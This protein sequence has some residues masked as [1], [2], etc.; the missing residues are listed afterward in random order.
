[1]GGMNLWTRIVG[2]DWAVEQL[3]SAIQHDRLGH[4]HL[5]TGPERVGK[6][7]L[8]RTLAQAVNCVAPEAAR[9]PC[10][11][12]R[13]C[14]LIAAD[15]HPDVRLLAPEVSARGLATIRIDQVRELA[16][17]LNLAP[18]E[19]RRRVAILRRIDAASI[20]A[21]NA[22]LKTLEEPP[23]GVLL[24]LTAPDAASLLPT[25]VSRC[26]HL[27]L[28][29]VP[30]ESI[31]ATLIERWG[32][33]ARHAQL[34]AHLAEGRIGWAI[35]A[36]QDDALL[37]DRAETLKQ[38]QLVLGADLLE[39]FASAERLA[40]TPEAL[41]DLIR[42]WS[43]WWRDLAMV[44]W[45]QTGGIVNLDQLSQMEQLAGAWGQ[46]AI[47]DALS[48]TQRAADQLWANANSRLLLENLFLAYPQDPTASD[49]P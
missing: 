12:C 42:G 7:S 47:L 21:A 8:A 19:A 4:A 5:I 15:R 45:R 11:Q 35:A 40:R 22:F 27:A 48:R 23:E 31:A 34:L 6:T 13:P 20:S 24:M 9:R 25:L 37:Q 29:P 1:M 39:R 41:P 36:L 2:H 38:L 33:D 16:A 10:G 32:A 3:R 26:R 17:D 14:G 43:A 49:G 18:Y 44:S 28:R 30:A 46:R